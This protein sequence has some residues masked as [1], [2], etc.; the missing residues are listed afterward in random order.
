MA[1]KSYKPHTPGQR[2][3]TTLVFDEL[4]KK[5]PEK[6][7]IKTSPGSGGRNNNG[8]ITM[9]RRGGAQ[10]R[11]YRVVDFKRDKFSIPAKVAAI[12]YDPN[13]SANLALLVYADGE[14]R[15][16][17]CPDGVA[18]GDVLLSGPEAPV[19]RGNALP[20]KD[21]P[22]GTQVHN[23]EMKPGKGAQ[24]ARGAGASAQIMAKEGKYVTIKLPSGEMRM[25]LENC[26]A[27]IGEVGNKDYSNVSIGKAG[28][29]RWLGKRPKVRG[30]AMNPH[31]HPM[32]GGEGKT[33]GG[34]HPATPWGKPTKG[35]KTRKKKN[36]SNKYIVARRKKK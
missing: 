16:I 11:F 15:Y 6:K 14:K 2:Y 34:G 33:S 5:E 23:I 13:R 7:L 31:D 28:R 25:I 26:L 9:R 27:T 19:K 22:A 20:L 3:K 24:I 18:V 35:Y 17:V 21:I 32:G 8:R 12:E 4:T 1:L 36:P 10:K 30:V 29:N